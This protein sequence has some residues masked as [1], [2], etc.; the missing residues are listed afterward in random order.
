M[1][2]RERVLRIVLLLLSRPFHFSRR[3]LAEDFGVSKNTMDE[4]IKEIKRAGLDFY[5][6]RKHNK[7]AIIPDRT[8][9]ELEYLMP[10]TNEDQFRITR[11]I[12]QYCGSTKEAIALKNKFSSLYDFQRLGIRA[13]R[14]PELEK[15]DRLEAAKKQKK[16]V[17]LENYRSNSNKIRN[18]IVEPFQ[19][20]AEQGMLQAFD[21][22]DQTTRHFKLNRI[23]RVLLTKISWNFEKRH[24]Y[25]YTDVFRIADNEKIMVHLLLDVYAFNALVENYPKA[26]ADV[27][28]GAQENT[29]DFQSSVNAGFLGL[30]NF[31]MGNGE[32]VKIVSPDILK[33]HILKEAQRII[34]NIK[35]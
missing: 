5:W 31:I 10:L 9:K 12:D 28:N 21:V 20:D 25:K 8:F 15:L 27:M 26:R 29:F 3:D 18:R 33:E 35:E 34:E 2:S 6:E 13:L 22:D 30:T 19:I 11:A 14:R 1:R 32:H 24:E 4:D 7:C 17:V 16:Q 23:K